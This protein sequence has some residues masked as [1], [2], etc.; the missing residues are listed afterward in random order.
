[1]REVQLF[2]SWNLTVPWIPKRSRLYPLEPMQIGTAEVE[3]LTGYVARLAE[4]HCVSVADLV[5]GELSDPSSSN[6]LLNPRIETNQSVFYTQ[7]YSINGI[8]EAPR[9]WITILE[10]ATLHQGLSDLTL[11][12]F[13]NLLSESGLF[14][15]VSAWCPRCFEDRRGCGA[16]YDSLL[17]AIAVVKICPIHKARLEEICPNC[18]RSSRPLAAYSR[19]GFCSRCKNWLGRVD[20]TRDAEKAPPAE[21]E[22]EVWIARA[23]SELLAVGRQM[24]NAGLR[25]R[26]GAIF[27]YASIS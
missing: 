7:P 9:R 12:R 20:S 21:V 25:E 19:P 23:V 15:S 1:M 5:G 16:V 6:P 4:A 18:H 11:L 14:R 17:W 3:S 10:A 8:G 24:E 26:L 22:R 2:E 13:E 27:P